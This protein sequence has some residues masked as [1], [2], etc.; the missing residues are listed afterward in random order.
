MRRL[1]HQPQRPIFLAA[2][3][4]LETA[5]AQSDSA[6]WDQ[7]AGLSLAQAALG[8][9]DG[10]RRTLA[11]LEACADCLTP[12]SRADIRS[13]MAMTRLVLGAKAGALGALQD[14]I[15]A[16]STLT[17]AMVRIDPAWIPLRGEPAFQRLI[18]SAPGG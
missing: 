5:L 9:A 2:R 1:K 11:R 15:G 16:P 13:G 17:A 8:D 4:Q 18:A 6:P 12:K 3:E 14:A 10:A 7:L